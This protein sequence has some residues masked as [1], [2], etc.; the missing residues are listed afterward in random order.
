MNKIPCLSSRHN[1]GFSLI[2]LLLVLAIVAAVAVAAFIVYPKVQASNVAKEEAEVI[3]SAVASIKEMFPNGNYANLSNQ[4]A[5]AAKI[6]PDNM[7]LENTIQNRF[8][9]T[10]FVGP[11]KRSV[12]VFKI[13]YM[14]PPSHICTKLVP[15]LAQ[16]FKGVN[17]KATNGTNYV[18]RDELRY[19]LGS[20]TDLRALDE[21]N[22]AM[23]CGS[24]G[25]YADSIVVFDF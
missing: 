6:F 13:T 21:N 10:V 5:I 8:G 3:T 9:S 15:L 14:R 1:H 19:F 18:V 11:S 17:V 2:E 16:R 22:I 24:A 23:G 12:K 25:G 4:V 20:S 7:L